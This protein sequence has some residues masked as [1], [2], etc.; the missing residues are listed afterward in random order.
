[1]KISQ[2]KHWTKT[3]E[4]LIV[5][6]ESSLCDNWNV[7]DWNFGNEKKIG[8]KKVVIETLA[9]KK[10]V[11]KTLVM[12]NLWWLKKVVIE[13]VGDQNFDNWKFCGY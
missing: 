4:P 1:M 9:T 2:K 10:V 7:G 11:T 5:R 13:N 3:I 6:C 8:L 12:K